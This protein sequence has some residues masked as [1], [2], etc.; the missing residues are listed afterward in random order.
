M[1]HCSVWA[2]FSLQRLPISWQINWEVAGLTPE[3]GQIVADEI[4]D[5]LHGHQGRL[6]SNALPLPRLFNATT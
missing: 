1:C 4:R 2:D 3:M 6:G 5:K